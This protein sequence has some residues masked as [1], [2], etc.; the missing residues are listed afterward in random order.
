MDKY[1][2]AIAKYPSTYLHIALCSKNETVI[3]M[4]PIHM[5]I[6]GRVFCNLAVVSE[7]TLELNWAAFRIIN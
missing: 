4:H 7:K 6:S 3:T 1:F 2:G 5:L